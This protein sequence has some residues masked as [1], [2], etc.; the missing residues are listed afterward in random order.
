MKILIFNWR[1]IYHP[2]AGGSELN[3]H[4]TAKRWVKRGNEVIMICAHHYGHIMNG[5]EKDEIDG[6]KIVRIGGRFSVYLLAPLYYMMRLFIWPD[7]I[8]DVEN[9]IPFFTPLFTTKP[10]CCLVNHVHKDIFPVE[11]KFP[12]SLIGQFLETKAM[13]FVYKNVLF[14]AISKATKE[15]LIEIGIPKNKIKIVY[16]GLDHDLYTANGKKSKNPSILYVG[17]LRKYKRVSLLIDVLSEIN[18]KYGIKTDLIIVGDGEDKSNIEK[19]LKKI[20]Y[21][22]RVKLKGYV[23]LKSKIKLLQSAWVFATASLIEGWGLSVIEAN[24]CGIPAVALKVPGL[25]DAILDGESGYLAN[26]PEDMVSKIAKLLKNSPLRREMGRNALAW[27]R[28]FS[29]EKTADQFLEIMKG[30]IK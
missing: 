28:E 5:R 19:I 4:E 9:G 20:P 11:M 6:I 2:W 17:R 16:A 23:N 3:I 30:R 18:S 21:K 26:S 29:W 15:E 8:I 22:E 24:A 27:S 1:D 10:I 7:I 14:I 12:L 25:S 13:P